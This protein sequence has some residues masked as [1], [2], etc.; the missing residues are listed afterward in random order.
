MK[1]I[2][3]IMA[4][5]SIL[6]GCTAPSGSVSP[7]QIVPPTPGLEEPIAPI[8]PTPPIVPAEFTEPTIAIQKVEAIVQSLNEDPN[9]SIGTD[10]LSLLE[11]EGLLDSE[12]EGWVK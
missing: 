12:L 9:Y 1:A 11:S 8:A 10:D 5:L 7:E 3:L 2:G 4:S 6:A